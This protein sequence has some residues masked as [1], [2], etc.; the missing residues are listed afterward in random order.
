MAEAVFAGEEVEE[1][2][3]QQR[4]GALAFS[5]AVFPHLSQDFLMGYCP[6]YACDRNREDKQPAI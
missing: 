6:G 1:L 2:S 4:T 5:T 3:C